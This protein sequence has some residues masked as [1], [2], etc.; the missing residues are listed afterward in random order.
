[1]KRLIIGPFF[2]AAGLIAG[3]G[4]AFVAAQSLGSLPVAAGSVWEGRDI[5][6]DSGVYPYTI[7]HYLLAGRLPPNTGQFIEL[8][9]ERDDKGALLSASCE[10]VLTLPAGKTPHWWSLTVFAGT[11]SPAGGTLS[12]QSAVS[13]ADGSVRIAVAREPQSGNWISAPEAGRFSLLYASKAAGED[14]APP[15]F[16][17]G[18]RRC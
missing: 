16:A 18:K 9:A 11:L 12:S 2:V 10:Y 7:A 14:V 4:S 13:E 5:S 6:P 1:M 3:L 17:I 15:V 8:T